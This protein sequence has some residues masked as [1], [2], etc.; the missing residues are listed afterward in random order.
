[1]EDICLAFTHAIKTLKSDNYKDP[2]L[3][4]LSL[5]TFMTSAHSIIDNYDAVKTESLNNCA[6][7]DPSDKVIAENE[8]DAI[9][10]IFE[11]AVHIMVMYSSYESIVC[12][13]VDFDESSLSS[14]I[15]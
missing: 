8:C 7:M 15:S 12:S 11:K 4:D 2:E 10:Q 9:R 1:M 6:L 3:I 13:G 5:E 14:I